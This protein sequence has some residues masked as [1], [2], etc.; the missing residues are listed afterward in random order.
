MD[1]LKSIR[2][3]SVADIVG[4]K[5][6]IKNFIEHIKNARTPRLLALVGPTG[7][8]K[9]LVCDL[10]FKELGLKCYSLD[11]KEAILNSKD[12]LS[13]CLDSCKKVFIVDNVD[14]L[15]NTDKNIL[16][17]IKSLVLK[18]TYMVLTYRPCSQKEICTRLKDIETFVLGYPP[19]RDSFIYLSGCL[20]C[21]D[22]KLLSLTK[23]YR[24]NIREIVMNLH[25]ASHETTITVQD[26]GFKDYSIFDIASCFLVNPRWDLL[27]QIS[28]TDPVMV[29]YIVYE[30]IIEEA[31]CRAPNSVM[32]AYVMSNKY[33]VE[34]NKMERKGLGDITEFVRFG[35]MLGAL[36]AASAPGQSHFTNIKFPKAFSKTRGAV[37]KRMNSTDIPAMD[38]IDLID[39]GK[40]LE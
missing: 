2:P 38:V 11:N 35:G 21:E 13:S 15:I 18:N 40:M 1:T 9:S 36:G 37:Q 29:S 6:V 17:A 32:M 31:H 30:N 4:N 22:E 14:A 33:M 26:R 20:G 24:G 16:A 23:A 34:A 25:Q 8:G 39:S 3:T 19:I 10:V 12:T 28:K 5:F 7:C 27:E